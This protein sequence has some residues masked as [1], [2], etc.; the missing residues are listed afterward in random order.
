MWDAPQGYYQIGV[1]EPD[2]TKWTCNLMPFGPVNSPARFVA[3]IHNVDSTWKSLASLH[4]AVIN[5]DTITNI[6][7]ND[8]VSRAK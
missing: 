3:F 7:V 1:E 5:E 8:I 6:I 2:A 4:G